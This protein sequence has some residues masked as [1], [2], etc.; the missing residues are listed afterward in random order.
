M[1]HCILYLVS[2]HLYCINKKWNVTSK[3]P[4]FRMFIMRLTVPKLL[5]HI[6]LSFPFFPFEWTKTW[7]I[8]NSVPL[9]IYHKK[10]DD[11]ILLTIPTTFLY[12][13]CPFPCLPL[14]CHQWQCDRIDRRQ[15]DIVHLRFRRNLD[16]WVLCAL[17]WTLSEVC[18]ALGSVGGPFQRFG[19][20]SEI[21]IL[22][23]SWSSAKGL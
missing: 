1:C 2:R 11:P 22:F 6:F 7:L 13:V 10:D 9:K 8:T 21:S 3:I 20:Y 12:P 5:S 4:I 14:R 23:S 19:W 18:S 17:V 15:F 16:R